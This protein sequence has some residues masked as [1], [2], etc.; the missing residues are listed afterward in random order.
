VERI[1]LHP[2]VPF[3]LFRNRAVTVAT[4]IGFLAGM[5]LFGAIA[6]VPL[7]IQL[8]RGGSATAAG[9]ILTPIYL[10]WVLA[11]IVAARLLLRVG[12]RVATVA[13]TAAV[14]VS[15]AALPWLA[16]ESSRAALVADMALLGA[17]MGFAM[18]SLLLTAQHSVS[19][20]ELGVAT[21]LNMFARSIGGAVGVAIM[22]AI[23]AAGVGGSAQAAGIE[24]A[25]LSGLSPELRRQMILS[26][27]RAF[28]T[29]AVA[30][31]L[32]VIASFHVP[33]LADV[34]PH[35][36]DQIVAAEIGAPQP[37]AH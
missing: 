30:A 11:S 24:H 35:I 12:A 10:T 27:H 32:A 5:G 9:Q 13:G 28:A 17:G 22:G 4:V 23:L 21:S 37:K 20:T 36:T 26:L 29:G 15:S 34:A 25:G 7:L 3:G 2:I 18:L 16:I 1:A 31:G 6:F 19:K 33:R 8:T 14:F